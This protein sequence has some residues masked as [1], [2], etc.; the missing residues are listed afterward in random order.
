MTPKW[1]VG[2]ASS[3]RGIEAK[4]ASL[5][6][7]NGDGIKRR[8]ARRPKSSRIGTKLFAVSSEAQDQR[9]ATG[10]TLPVIAIT[11]Y[12]DV[13]L[14]VRAMRTGAVDFAENRLPRTRF[15][16]PSTV[17][18]NSASKNASLS[19]GSRGRGAPSA[20]RARD[21]ELM[22]SVPRR[23]R[24]RLIT[25]ELEISARRLEIHGAHIGKKPGHAAAPSSFGRQLPALLPR[26]PAERADDVTS[27]FGHCGELRVA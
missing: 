22:G 4:E 5:L 16:P 26:V 7:S 3:P 6:L 14:A 9:R 19:G 10:V 20:L 11:G 24:D 15:S 18:S 27:P 12:G 8:D 13:L 21:R 17:P 25:Y 2:C 1:L 23:K